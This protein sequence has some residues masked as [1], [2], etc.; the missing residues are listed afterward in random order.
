MIRSICT[1]PITLL[2]TK[3]IVVKETDDKRGPIQ[4]ESVAK[5][6]LFGFS[7][8][9]GGGG[10]PHKLSYALITSP[11]VIGSANVTSCWPHV[12]CSSSPASTNGV[13]NAQ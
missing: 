11:C 8:N 4:N 7:A 1:K 10:V 5:R 3:S 9:H 2:V 6:N 12:Q 13:S